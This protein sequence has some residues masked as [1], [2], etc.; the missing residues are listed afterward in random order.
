MK[1]I[2]K[3]TI[4]VFSAIVLFNSCGD[5]I[6]LYP[7][8]EISAA[9]ALNSTTK[10]QTA[11]IGCYDRL[12][13]GYLYGG[14]LW[15]SGDMLAD[16][17][18]TS[19][20]QN[21]VFEELQMLNKTMSADNLITSVI[22]QDAYWIV[23]QANVIIEAIPL[24]ED[25]E[26]EFQKDQ[27]RGE[28]L[29]LRAIMHF[30]LLRNFENPQLGLGIPLILEAPS[31]DDQP[32]RA[33]IDEC[34]NSI[35]ADLTEAK[36]LLPESNNGMATSWSAK[37]FLS[38]ALFYHGDFPECETVSTEIIDNG[39]FILEDSIKNCFTTEKS[40]EVLFY[41]MS[42]ENDYSCGTLN[43]YYR[44]E[45]SAKFRVSGSYINVLMSAVG[46]GDNRVPQLYF[47]D[48]E[49]SKIYTTKFNDLY[50]NVPIIRLSEIYLNRAESRVNIN[51]N[52]D[53]GA[54]DDL[55]VVRTRAGLPNTTVASLTR[56]Y[57]ERS[58]E[59]AFEGDNFHNLK[60]LKVPGTAVPALTG[61]SRFNYH[62]DDPAIIMKISQ[63]ELDINENLIPN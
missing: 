30:E 56:C 20:L 55:N 38:R 29:F 7:E 57:V 33:T 28:A 31:I 24:V 39:G 51:G 10:L 17:V 3:Y 47:N 2:I 26:I 40:D 36:D 22:W 21:T 12:Q 13:S 23:A 53:P 32:A 52:N 34:Y 58:Q 48:V 54:L 9:T 14:R 63:R 61:I 59:L 46:Q 25:V 1:N 6:D 43:G 15:V 27:I 45:S 44:F 35:I 41:L 5:I 11:V 62:W 42:A 49:N 8:N 50:M 18:M 4:I 19:G 16:N 37:A 60:R